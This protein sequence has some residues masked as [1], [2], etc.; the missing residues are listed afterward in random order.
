MV[1]LVHEPGWLRTEIATAYRKR[2]PFRLGWEYLDIPRWDDLNDLQLR[3][4]FLQLDAAPEP[5]VSSRAT[6]GPGFIVPNAAA[7]ISM[8]LPIVRARTK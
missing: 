1:L 3:Q 8:A 5:L 6:I 2:R 4:P 7:A